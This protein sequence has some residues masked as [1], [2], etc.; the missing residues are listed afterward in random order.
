MRL[1]VQVYRKPPTMDPAMVIKNAVMI[2]PRLTFSRVT[3][4]LRKGAIYLEE[5][6]IVF[7]KD[8]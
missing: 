1:E 5:L 4:A 2:T 7:S 8:R 3:K 6:V